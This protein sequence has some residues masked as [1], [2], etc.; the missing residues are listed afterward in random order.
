MLSDEDHMLACQ[1]GNKESLEVLYQR[2]KRPIFGF[3]L[4]LLGRRADAEDVAAEVFVKLAEG[5]NIFRPEAKFSTWIFTVARN[6]AID[7]I[8]KNKKMTSSDTENSEPMNLQDQ[9]LNP[10]EQLAAKDLGEVI[11]RAVRALPPPQDEIL[12]LREYQHMSYG[13]ISEVTGYS[14]EKVKVTIFRARETLRTKLHFLLEGR[15]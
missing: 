3:A 14:I 15:P 2:W 7:K 9:T 11:G 10:Q 6:L 5:R 12:V 1:Q 13:E 4:R 8:R